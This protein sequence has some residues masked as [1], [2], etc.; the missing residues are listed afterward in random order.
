[1]LPSCIAIIPARGGSKRFPRKNI[2]LFN[3]K[4]LIGHAVEIAL[5]SNFVKTV[6]VSTDDQEIANIAL[7]YGAKV[8]FLR[9]PSLA[10]DVTTIDTVASDFLCSLGREELETVDCVVLQQP[11]SPVLLPSQIDLCVDLLRQ[12]PKFNSV[13]TL[14]R[15]D[16]RHH[17]LN[18]AVPQQEQSWE[19]LM[20]NDRQKH[21]SRQSKPPAF[22]FANLFVT[23]LETLQ[24]GDR[25]GEN[26]GFIEL[27][28]AF[29]ADID[30][31]IDLPI[32]EL[33]FS[34]VALGH[35]SVA[36]S[37]SQS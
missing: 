8:P 31:P 35:S 24:T 3:G 15:L 32:A 22:K 21:K 16:N 23:R 20:G 33:L 18:I 27:E 1:M 13:T 2:A 26:K 11:T 25:F 36:E 37:G 9:P 30:E 29:A 7:K 4:P 6:Y 5:A 28:Q 34:S 14:S 12:N 19:F 10:D 17:P